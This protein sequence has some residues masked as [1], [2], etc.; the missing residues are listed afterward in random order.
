MVATII[1]AIAAALYLAGFIFFDVHRRKK[2]KKS[3]FTEEYCSCKTM[4]SRR[5]I[6]YYRRQKK[7]EARK[8]ER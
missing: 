8:G 4:N 5:L 6:A 3:F 1:I 7:A 2:G